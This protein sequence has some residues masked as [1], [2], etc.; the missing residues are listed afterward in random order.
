MDD[1]IRIVVC[2]G[3]SCFVRGNEKNLELIEKFLEKHVLAARVLVSGSLCECCCG[4]GPNI[5]INDKVFHAVSREKL[6]GIL[7][8]ELLGVKGKGGS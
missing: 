8:R 2:M 3:S 7:E 5:R 6:P 4:Q 1:S